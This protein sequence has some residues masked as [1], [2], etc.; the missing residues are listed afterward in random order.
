MGSFRDVLERLR[1]QLERL[2]ATLKNM[3]SDAI[4]G[5]TTNETPKDEPQPPQAPVEPPKPTYLWDTKE[6]A[7]HSVRVI[8]DEMGLTVQ[9]KNDLCATVGAESGWQSYYLTGLKK[10]QPV[11]RENKKGGIVW[12]TDWG[13]SQINDWYHIGKGKEFPSVEYVLNN[14]EAV[15]RWMCKMWKAGHA[16]W[17]IAYKSGAYRAYL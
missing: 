9:Q 17:W 4:N 16:D 11:K 8:C 2:L 12:S 7:R 6:H 10:G 5:P 13:I 1:Q 15:I 3:P 14:P